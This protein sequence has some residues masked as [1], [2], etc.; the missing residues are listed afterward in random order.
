[1]KHIVMFSGG[2]GSW[3]TAMKVKE[4]YGTDNLY[5]VFADTL[6]EDE[7]LYRF[8]KES[9]KQIGAKLI[10]LKDGRD[11]WQVFKD[12]KF[13]GNNRIANCSR[14][15]K[16][17]P[18]RKWLEE[19]AKPD[20]C[21]VYVG[22]DWTETHRL[23]AIVNNYLPYTAK[24]PLCEKPYLDKSEILEWMSK[25]GIKPPRLYGMGFAH[26]NCGGFCVR[27]GHAQFKKLLELFPDRY[28]A[29]EAKEEELRKIIGKDVSIM[30]DRRNK[31]TKPMTMK[32]FRERLVEEEN[33]LDDEDDWGGCGCFVDNE[34]T[35]K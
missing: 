3:A 29:H 16:Q 24:A 31:T 33:K 18:S 14:Y 7:D 23:P 25:E 13:I 34:G 2:A 22:I 28:A 32:Q 15:L 30:K 10:W 4:Q 21:V 9:E 26:N 8:I 6:I 27:S 11:V 35:E 5:L 20:E 1:M 12:D 19:N 17:R